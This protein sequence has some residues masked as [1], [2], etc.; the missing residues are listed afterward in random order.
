MPRITLDLQACQ[1]PG[2]SATP[3][4]LPGRL[5]LALLGKDDGSLQPKLAQMIKL[6]LRMNNNND[7]NNDNNNNNDV[8]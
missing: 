8:D 4:L 1:T 5:H 2:V 6:I 3:T 7:N